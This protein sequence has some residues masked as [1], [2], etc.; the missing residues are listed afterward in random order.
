MKG[1]LS[2]YYTVAVIA[3]WAII[4]YTFFQGFYSYYF[5][6]KEQTQLFLLSSQYLGTYFNKPAWLACMIGDFLTQF[7]YY[8]FAGAIILVA[9]LLVLG[10]ISRR[11]LQRF[12]QK[13]IAFWIAIIIITVEAIC[14]FKA[15]FALSSTIAAIG[16]FALFYLYSFLKKGWIKFVVGI[17]VTLSSYWLFGY[18]CFVFAILAVISDIRQSRCREGNIIFIIIACAF[19]I[20]LRGHYLLTWQESMTYPGIG[21]LSTPNFTIEKIFQL[22]NEYYF[23]HYDK[24]ANIARNEKQQ[25]PEVAYFYNLVQARRGMLPDNLFDIYQPLDQ[26]LFIKSGPDV[27]MIDL[28]IQGAMFYLWGDMTFFEHSST[29]ANTFSPNNRNVR[30][31]KQLAEANL[32]NNDSTAAMKY[33][34]LLQ[35]TIVYRQWAENRMPGKQTA[36]V[37][38]EI[39]EKRQFI[40]RTDTLRLSGGDTYT[41]ITGLLKSNPDN[42]IALDYLLCSE[43]LRKDILNFKKDYDTYCQ[44]LGKPREKALYQE[45]LLIY[46]AGSNS[47]TQ[48]LT[49]YKIPQDMVDKFKEY[50]KIYVQSKGDRTMLT[51]RF[52]HTYWYYF[53]FVNTK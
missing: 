32:I 42:V 25:I 53:H 47:A 41:V 26:G 11:S 21:K 44:D 49:D 16:G 13:D 38:K 45:A 9:S 46:F 50:T 4:C 51:E 39:R 28:Y 48:E 20:L 22:D 34:R 17:A 36:E 12:I 3:I 14:H 33:L 43:L 8:R 5:F 30:M 7:Y 10:D 31:I 23:G 19:A 18:G 24:V 35:K 27:A 29:L 6:Y 52:E 15:G 2:K 40:N 1:L 37:K